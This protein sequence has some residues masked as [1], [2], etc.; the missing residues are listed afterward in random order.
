MSR[1]PII[2]CYILSCHVLYMSTI[3]RNH[4]AWHV[5]I[6]LSL[7]LLLLLLDCSLQPTLMQLHNLLYLLL[8]LVLQ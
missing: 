8:V 6:S 1:L 2:N 5:T 7:S 3:D 4:V